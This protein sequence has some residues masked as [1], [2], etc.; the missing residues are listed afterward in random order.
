MRRDGFHGEAVA[1]N[2]HAN[3]D[4]NRCQALD[5]VGVFVG[6]Q[7]PIQRFRSPTDLSQTLANLAATKSG[8]DKDAS[9]FGFEI[10]AV[11]TGAAAQ[12]C[13]SNGHS[14]KLRRVKCSRNVFLRLLNFRPNHTELGQKG[15]AHGRNAGLSFGQKQPTCR[16]LA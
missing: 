15:L 6:N 1:K 14:L 8:V 3:P 12:D 16:I 2:G 4:A 9:L 5:M 7:D 10:C 11:T 13:E